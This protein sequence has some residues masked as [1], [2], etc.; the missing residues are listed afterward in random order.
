MNTST[1][2]NARRRTT[3]LTALA[4]AATLAVLGLTGCIKVD[5]VVGIGPDTTGSGTFALEFQKEAA[6]FL[7]ITDLASFESQI[8]EGALTEGDELDAFTECVTSENDTAYVYTCTFANTEFTDPEGLWQITKEGEEIVFTMSSPGAGEEAAGAEDL[9]G[10]ASMG[11]I[12]VTAEF[13]G[14][15]TSIEGALVEQT[16]ENEAVIRASMMDEITVTI[17]SEAGSSG[18]SLSVILVIAV[19][20]G[21]I[22]LLIVAVVLL[23]M[24]RR[25]G[26]SAAAIGAAES[27]ST[28]D[29]AEPESVEL[30]GSDAPAIEG[31]DAPAIEGTDEDQPGT[32]PPA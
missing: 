25:A 29:A 23:V 2:S 8:S 22:V 9:L 27:A 3:R 5:A 7:G 12:N 17:R 26:T 14:P 28:V 31:A 19:T 20:A 32:T 24:R 1:R 15:I 6:G 11:G 21:I 30:P 16:S 4:G 10:G 18:P 13:P